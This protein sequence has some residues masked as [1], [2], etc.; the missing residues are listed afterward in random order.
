MHIPSRS[1]TTG[2]VCYCGHFQNSFKLIQFGSVYINTPSQPPLTAIVITNFKFT[3]GQ[4]FEII[5]NQSFLL[6]FLNFSFVV[7]YILVNLVLYL[8]DL[9][10]SFIESG[11][12]LPSCIIGAFF[13]S[14]FVCS[15]TTIKP[16][17]KKVS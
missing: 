6:L 3:C 10:I 2:T 12:T 16:K 15:K 9:S 11:C 14:R 7:P 1:K 5:H 13:D 4:L 8:L 17:K